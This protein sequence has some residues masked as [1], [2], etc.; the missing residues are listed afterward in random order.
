MSPPEVRPESRVPNEREVLEGLGVRWPIPPFVVRSEPVPTVRSV[1][2][3]G[4]GGQSQIDGVVTLIWNGAEERFAIEYKAPGT[5][6]Q[7]E[8]AIAQ[9]GRYVGTLPDLRPLI[10]APFIKPALLD[11]LVDEGISA[12]DL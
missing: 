12:V 5:P 7:V 10:I 8:A 11:R 4:G 9:L 1:R 3:G 6:K 2:E